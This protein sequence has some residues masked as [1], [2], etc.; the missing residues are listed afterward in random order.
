M[1]H[2][3]RSKYAGELYVEKNSNK[4]LI[5]RAGWMMGGG[6]KK[7]KK[8]VNKILKQVKEGKK[9]LFVVND[10]MGTPTYTF[11]FAEN[12]KLVLESRLWGLYNMVCE[13]M[14]GRFEVTQELLK[15]MELDKKIK[16]T[17]VDSSFFEKEYFATRPDSERLINRKLNLRK[18]N[19][20]RDWKVC[21]KEYLEDYYQDFL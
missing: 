21:L 16:L 8:F 4:Y 12:V 10:K 18:M 17:E 15:V 11:D 3:A 7:D 19:I 14:T 20:M 6:P 1:C 9:E 5:C 2:Y 13:G